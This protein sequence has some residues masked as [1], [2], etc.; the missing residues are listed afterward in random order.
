MRV[1]RSEEI[2]RAR[3]DILVHLLAH[4]AHQS[5]FEMDRN[6]TEF[7]ILHSFGWRG[8]HTVRVAL[9]DLETRRLISRHTQYVVGYNEPKTLFL[10]T[11]SGR[12]HSKKLIA[13]NGHA[14]A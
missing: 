1:D 8:T 9:Q 12:L 3:E 14:R 7:A 5:R 10:L 11:Q 4:K 13:E 2:A 6:T